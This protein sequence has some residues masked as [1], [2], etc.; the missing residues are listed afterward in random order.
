MRLISLP[1][2]APTKPNLSLVAASALILACAIASVALPLATY[3]L[4][5]AAFGLAHVLTELRY[6]DARFNPRT[7]RDLRFGIA[8]LL[9]I[10]VTLRT[11]LVLGFLSSSAW[12]IME[13]T[14]VVTLIALVVPVLASKSWR[15]AGFGISAIVAITAGTL[16]APALTFAILSVAHNITPVGFIAERLLGERRRNAMIAC[17]IV[18]AVIP[19]IIISGFPHKALASVS[20]VAP[21]ASLLNAGTLSEHLGQFVPK[22]LHSQTIGLHAFSA[23]VFLQCM[24]Y[25]AVIGILPRFDNTATWGKPRAFL[26]WPNPKLF[27]ILILILG[28]LL[29]AGFA[30][31]FRDSRSLYGIVASIHAWLELPILLLA[32]AITDRE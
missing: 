25:V 19:L 24:H 13:L 4:T 32:L 12:V 28:A 16:A 5:L 26:P 3:T 8:Q 18:F 20:L 1:R 11:L 21:E 23:A 10:I 14:C 29:F 17:A 9:L 31:S 6:V 27:H 7:G 2:T 15:L 22:Q 30:Q